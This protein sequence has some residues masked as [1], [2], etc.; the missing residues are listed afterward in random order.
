MHF[1][2][3]K[4]MSTDYGIRLRS[5]LARGGILPFIGVYDVFSACIAAKHFEGIFVS[6]FSFAA[7]HYGLPDI[8]FIAWSD[9]V[10]FVQRLRTVVPDHHIL[11]DIDDG[12]AD[13]EVACHVV[14]M[15][16]SLG[17]SGVIL[18]DQK[19]P[20]R[21][22]HLDGKKI[23]DLE[24]YLDRLKRVLAVR[25][26]LFV[27]ARTDATDIS[28]MERRVIAFAEAGADAVLVDAIPKIEWI[29][30]FRRRI[31]MPFVVNQIAGGKS[32]RSTLPQ[33]QEAGAS[34]AIFST[35]CLFAAQTAIEDALLRLREENGMLPADTSES[36]SVK[37]C[38]SLL[39]K[40]LRKPPNAVH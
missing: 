10:G 13:T 1:Q 5:E 11:V 37:K 26:N 28:E 25:R 34:I 29:A 27:V 15:L 40:N 24:E 32:P 33:L 39:E 31:D 18:E 21:C 17:A 3:H 23:M 22:G 8:G 4:Q 30:K 2:Y 35:P 36:G 14:A 20:I 7:S 19:R 16:E 9:I 12:Y 38:N 6:G